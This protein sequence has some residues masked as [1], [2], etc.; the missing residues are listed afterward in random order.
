M[1]EMRASKNKVCSN[2]PTKIL[3]LPLIVKVLKQ[4]HFVLNLKMADV[5]LQ[6]CSE[7]NLFWEKQKSEGPLN[8]VLKIPRDTNLTEE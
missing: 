5:L 7:I 1:R 3:V 2:S 8:D 6:R 4:I